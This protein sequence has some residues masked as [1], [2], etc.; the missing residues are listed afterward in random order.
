MNERPVSLEGRWDILYRDYPEVYDAFARIP[1][2]PDMLE[3]LNE[4]FGFAGKVIV[5]VGSGTGLSTFQLARWA[6]L[7]IGIEPE[8]AM[9]AVAL[10]E[11]AALGLANVRFERGD[12]EHIPLHDGY[13]DA[14]VG[15]T[16]ANGD[17]RRVCAEMERVVR[18]GGVVLHC[19]VAPGWYGGELETVITGQP[20]NEN[21]NPI[22]PGGI[23]PS[24][25]YS[26]FDTFMDQD[27]DS[28]EHMVNTYGFI[29]GAQAIDYI[30]E[31]QITSIR[32]KFRTH[33]KIVV[34][35]PR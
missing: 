35:L 17:P 2:R 25:G 12:A 20:R 13:A 7:V 9:R 30:R 33:W 34:R 23:L 15:I 10:R 22:W 21:L 19:D 29:H 27:Y 16:Q 24:L 28:V 11:L 31:H 6:A 3:V 32:W 8:D 4:R 1:K 26:F 14:A 5:D 18:D